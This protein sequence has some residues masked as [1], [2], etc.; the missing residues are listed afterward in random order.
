VAKR[1]GS[2]LINSQQPCKTTFGD[3]MLLREIITRERLV[4]SG[5]IVVYGV[6]R[7]HSRMI[8]NFLTEGIRQSGES[9]HVI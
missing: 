2:V 6:D 4:D 8:P 9:P 5:E 1:L 3:Q 7:N